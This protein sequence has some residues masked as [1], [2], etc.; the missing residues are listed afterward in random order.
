MPAQPTYTDEQ[1]KSRFT[2]IYGRE[3]SGNE[4]AQFKKNYAKRPAKEKQDE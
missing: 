3:P 4:F 1:L 2:K